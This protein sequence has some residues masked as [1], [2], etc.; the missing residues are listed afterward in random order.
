MLYKLFLSSY[1]RRNFDITLRK[2]IRKR[3]YALCSRD[4]HYPDNICSDLTD[5]ITYGF[6][7]KDRRGL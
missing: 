3:Y 2:A 4:I 6:R 7:Y 5:E 1:P